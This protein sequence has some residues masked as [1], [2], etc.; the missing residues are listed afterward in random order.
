[1]KKFLVAGA[2]ALLSFSLKAAGPAVVA[3]PFFDA[4]GVE[5][6]TGNYASQMQERLPGMSPLLFLVVSRDPQGVELKE[7]MAVLQALDA[8]A[9]QL[10]FIVGTPSPAPTGGYW[11][12]PDGVDALLE[13]GAGFRFIALGVDAKPCFSSQQVVGREQ[14]VAPDDSLQPAFSSCRQKRG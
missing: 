5:Y 2:L 7:Q 4:A 1:M 8:E 10:V 3:V 6:S 9:L 13:E 14:I 12:A 11:L